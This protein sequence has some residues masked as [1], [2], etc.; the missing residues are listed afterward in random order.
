MLSFFSNLKVKVKIYLLILI[1]I[2]SLAVVVIPTINELNSTIDRVE[3]AN[4]INKI[5]RRFADMRIQEKN[6]AIR[7]DET[8]IKNHEKLYLETVDILN[9]LEKRFK[10]PENL[11]SLAQ[12]KEKLESYKINFQKFV[13]SEKNRSK[14]YVATP[15][16]EVMINNARE[17]DTVVDS[18]RKS[19]DKQAQ[20]DISTLKTTLI[21]ISIIALL[22]LILFGTTLVNSIIHA[23][24]A[25]Q[26]GLRSFFSFLNKETNKVEKIQLDTTDEF[27]EMAKFINKNIELTEKTINDDNALIEEAKVVMQRVNNGWYSQYIEKSTPNKALDEF[28][29]NVNDMIKNTKNRF[30]EVDEILEEY[31]TYNYTKTLQMKPNDENGG[32]F[33]RLVVG[34]NSLQKAVTNM[35]MESQTN[36]KY[37]ENASITL[38]QNVNTLSSSANEAAAS[39]EETAAALEEITATVVSNSNNISDM[40]RYSKEVTKSATQGQN[41]A[42]NTSNAMDELSNEIN[43]I[44]EAISVIDQIAFQTNILSL[45]AAV[46]AATA[47]EAGKGFAVVA[48]EVRNLANRSAEAA[49]EIKE[50]VESTTRKA[51][52]GKNITSNMILGYDEL[53]EN[54]NKTIDMINEITMSSKEQEAGI[55][56]INDAVTQLDQQTQQNAAIANE[57]QDIALKTDSIARNII[58]DLKDKVFVGKI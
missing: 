27:G 57:T 44:N 34:I 41:L 6:Y 39:L 9:L 20:D 45:N 58:E 32:V 5:N 21:T 29:N 47:G 42:K 33:E 35:L 16:E 37:L 38:K 50:I 22:V 10:N 53:L 46:E 13:D 23:L 31:A 30:L 48:Q 19:Q 43:L 11:K 4:E 17:V 25:V 1:G 24:E 51:N 26:N 2:I 40:D 14:T 55:T 56:Q 15:E 18:F 28:K 7:H 3:K 49:K 52:D 8:S 54:I 12:I 36:G